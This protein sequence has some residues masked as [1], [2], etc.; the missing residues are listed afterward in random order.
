MA[1]ENFPDA[2]KQTETVVQPQQNK[3]RNYLTAGLVIALLGTWAYI[4]WDKNKRVYGAD[5][6]LKA[7]KRDKHVV[8]VCTVER[9]MRQMGLRGVIR[10]KA[11]RTTFADLKRFGASVVGP[12][13]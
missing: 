6:V 4:I 5:K 8:A 1:F 13:A 11:Q 3:W 2:E 10:G 9:L 7:M 12:P